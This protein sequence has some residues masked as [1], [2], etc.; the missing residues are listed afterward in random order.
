MYD[1]WPATGVTGCSATTSYVNYEVL[2]WSTRQWVTPF[3]SC[4]KVHGRWLE[5]GCCIVVA[6]RT[7]NR[8]NQTAQHTRETE[9]AGMTSAGVRVG[10]GTRFIYDGETVE[11]I[12]MSPTAAGNE[13]V[14][15]SVRGQSYRTAPG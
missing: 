10:V 2:I 9:E 3:A 5:Q 4:Q 13:M 7:G 11:V 14:L 1:S 15:K 8:L 6:P 12:E